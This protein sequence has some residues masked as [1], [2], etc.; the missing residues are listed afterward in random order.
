[1]ARKSAKD[2]T[3]SNQI[4]AQSEAKKKFRT[5]DVRIGTDPNLAGDHHVRAYPNPVWAEKGSWIRG[6]RSA[7]Q[8]VGLSV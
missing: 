4:R 7:V 1:M 6:H 2:G 5:R 3:K 8:F